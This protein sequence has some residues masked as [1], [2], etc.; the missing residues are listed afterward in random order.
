MI[1]RKY[2]KELP[3]LSL[4][5]EISA[6]SPV[7]LR[8]WFAQKLADWVVSDDR[9]KK[10][11]RLHSDA[12]IELFYKSIVLLF[13]LWFVVTGLFAGILVGKVSLAEFLATHSLPP[14]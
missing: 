4:G 14:L 11:K 9:Y 6:Q 8:S 5:A 7:Q 12:K 13:W 10:H 3:E 1:E 2:Q